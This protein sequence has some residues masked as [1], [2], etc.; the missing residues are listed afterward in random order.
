M[1]SALICQLV[2]VDGIC[3]K[4]PSGEGS[5][6]VTEVKLFNAV[7]HK[8]MSLGVG[9]LIKNSVELC[10]LQLV[11]IVGFIVLPSVQRD[12]ENW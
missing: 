10:P 4:D 2:V 3:K 8:A 9:R 12:S 7:H 6:Y 5:V 11:S 1:W